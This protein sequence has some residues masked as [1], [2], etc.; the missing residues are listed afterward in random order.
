MVSLPNL[1]LSQIASR[2]RLEA[3]EYGRSPDGQFR[4]CWLSI[5]ENAA[6]LLDEVEGDVVGFGVQGLSSFNVDDP[7]HAPFWTAARFNVP[8][9]GLRD[10]TAAEVILAARPFLGGRPTVNRQ[11]FDEACEMGHVDRPRALALWLQCLES[12]DV[13]AHFAIGYTMYE[14][15]HFSVA[16]RHLRY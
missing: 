1:F 7:A 12:G 3:V 13:M 14:L 11:L 15:G 9:L 10:A 16:Y 8:T 5:G 6:F 4:D 2:D